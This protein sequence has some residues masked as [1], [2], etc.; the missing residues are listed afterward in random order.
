MEQ[1]SLFDVPE[2]T[3]QVLAQV[4]E[5]TDEEWREQALQAVERT[6][7]SLP[8]FISDDVWDTGALESTREDRALGPIMLAA[9]NRGWCTKTDRVRPSKRSHLSGKPVWRSLLY[10]GGMN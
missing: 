4:E 8:E 9:R 7:L 10:R 1:S 2:Q 3:A 6:C 5:N